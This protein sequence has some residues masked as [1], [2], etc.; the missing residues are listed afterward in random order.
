MLRKCCNAVFDILHADRAQLQSDRRDRLNRSELADARGNRR[1]AQ[2]GDPR[3]TPHY[4]FQQLEPFGSDR[5]LECREAGD[6]ATRMREALNQAA[7][8][9]VNDTREHD[10]NRA[11]RLLQSGYGLGGIGHDDVGREGHKLGGVAAI[12]LILAGAPADIEV[13]IAAFDPAQL[14][15]PRR[16]V[17]APLRHYRPWP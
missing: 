17:L 14:L 16:D 1:V 15:E 6:I 4:L 5:I 12:A 2:H 10:G 13:E 8:H 9:G 11:G 7:A 3:Q